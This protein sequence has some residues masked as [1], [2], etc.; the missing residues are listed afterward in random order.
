MT[1]TSI[2]SPLESQPV[3]DFKFRSAF[4]LSFADLSPIVGIYTVFAIGLIAAGPAFLWAFPLVLVGQLMVCGVFGNLVSKWPL[5]GSVYAWSREL[6]GPRYGWFT[7]WAYMWGL[8]L[9]LAVLPITAAPYILGAAGVTAPSQIVVELVAIGVLL[10]GSI[11]NVFG[12]RLLRGL[13][14]IALVCELVASAGIGL[15]LLIFHRINPLSIIF[16]TGGTGHGAGWLFGAFLLPVAYIAYS[17]IGF[18]ASASIGEEVQ[19]S[20]KVLPKA[21]VLSLAVGGVLVIVACLGLVLAMPDVSAAVSGK[22]ANP[23]ATTLGAFLRIGGGTDTAHRAGDRLHLQHDRGADGGDPRDLGQRPGPAAARDPAAGQAVRAGAPA[24]VRDRPDR[25]HRRRA[26]LRRRVQGVRAAGVVLGVRFHPVLLPADR[27]AELQAV[28]RPVAHG[29]RVG[30]TLDTPDHVHCRGLAERRDREPAVAQGGQQRVVPQLGRDHHDRGAGRA[31]RTDL[32]AVLPAGVARDAGP[33]YGHRGGRGVG[34]RGGRGMTAVALISGAASGIGR[35]CAEVMCGAGWQTAGIDLNASDTD[36]S[37]RADVSDRAAVLGAVDQVV[38]RFG[39]IDLLVTAAGYYE[40]G[41]DVADITVAQWDRMLG[42]ILGGTVNCCAAVLPHML[43]RDQGTIVAI[44]SELALA[45]SATDLHYVAAK[46]A[47]L[48]LIKSLA[49]E[50]AQT[51]IRV[52]AVA[53]GPTD[54]PLLAPDS[55]WREPSYLSTLPLGRLVRPSEIA[56]AVYY[57]ATEGSMYCGEVLSPNAG[58]VI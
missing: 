33:A 26:D 1:E 36:L 56:S 10:F 50:V 4:S 39:R 52:N 11:A 32:P 44:S 14:Y 41:I 37:L 6:I 58:A 40:E 45:G 53:P 49:M 42:V 22:D 17:F 57:L 5:Q 13:I 7:G 31:R 12:G 55:L 25:H 28:A 3:R 54:T 20:R 35:A 30:G 34:G 21:M 48:G 47:V 16:N 19:E 2:S 27:G 51:A 15:T 29:R 8:T 24:Q 38:E 9:T 18:E 43:S 23:I 46:G